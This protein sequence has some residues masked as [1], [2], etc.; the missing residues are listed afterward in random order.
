MIEIPDVTDVDRLSDW[1]ELYV[2][3]EKKV[4]SK[5]K[6]ISILEDNSIE[7][8][9]DKVDSA[10]T[11]LDRRLILYG[12]IKPYEVKGTIISP[13]F[14]WKRYPEHTLC[15]YY[16]TYGAGSHDEGTKLFE[17]VT[18]KCV[19]NELKWKSI[20]FGF[21]ASISFKS[22]LDTFA[23]QIHEHRDE[24]PSP[25]DKDRDVDIV[26]WKQFD[27]DRSNVIL[28]FI[29]C[30]AGK[31]WDGKKPVAITSYRRFVSFNYKVA[32]PSLSI[33]QII[34]IS[35]WRN[36]TD[37]YGIVLDRARLFRMFTSS[38]YRVNAQLKKQLSNWCKSKLHK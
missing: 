22:Q 26:V 28:L 31:N 30:A 24:N 20:L 34:S 14:D 3:S 33:T 7:S 17:Q 29:Q 38:T 27:D 4:I 12:K 21:P 32:I 23:E 18:K 13:K 6:I 8:D 5:S 37:D 25:H 1:I 9:E 15:L 35:D 2:L 11:E 10:I 19:E 16:S 36:A